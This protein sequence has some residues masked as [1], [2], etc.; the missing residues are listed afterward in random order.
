MAPSEVFLS[1]SAKDRAFVNRLAD[2]LERHSVP[3]W[4]S[5]RRLAPGQQWHDEIGSA[6]ARCDWF[7]VILSGS[8]VRAKWVKRELV[9]AL[10]DDRCEDRIVPV[11]L[12]SCDYR[13]LSWTLGGFQMVDF[14][15]D[16]DKGCTEMLATWGLAYTPLKG[17]GGAP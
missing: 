1:H 16:F 12:E 15:G 10:S 5:K 8:S 3:Y 2:V 11:L 7:A 9:Y 6:L 13:D 14:Q 4:Y 17:V